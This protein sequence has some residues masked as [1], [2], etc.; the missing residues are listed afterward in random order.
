MNRGP[1]ENLETHSKLTVNRWLT[2]GEPMV[3]RWFTDGSLMAK[4]KQ[5]EV[6]LTA[7]IRLGQ[8]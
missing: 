6:S 7:T 4:E 2:E 1:F 5:L 3:H 8:V